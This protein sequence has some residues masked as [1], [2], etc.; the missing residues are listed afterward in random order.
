MTYCFESSDILQL[1]ALLF[2]DLAQ[3]NI[4]I[5]FDDF[6]FS[7]IPDRQLPAEKRLELIKN[8]LDPG[9][10]AKAERWLKT[11]ETLRTSLITSPVDI[12]YCFSTLP[13]TPKNQTLAKLFQQYMDCDLSLDFTFHAQHLIDVLKNH[14]EANPFDD[15]L[16]FVPSCRSYLFSELAD[17]LRF[18]EGVKEVTLVEMWEITP[19]KKRPNKKLLVG[20]EVHCLEALGRHIKNRLDCGALATQIFVPFFGEPSELQYFKHYLEHLHIPYKSYIDTDK[21]PAATGMLERI[22]ADTQKP[23][24]ERLQ[25][26]RAWVESAPWLPQSASDDERLSI[27][28]AG[29]LLSEEQLQYF[30][31]LATVPCAPPEQTNGVRIVPF[32]PQPF[33]KGI[34]VFPYTG[35]STLVPPRANLLLEDT[36]MERLNREGFSLPTARQYRARQDTFLH[37]FAAGRSLLF[38]ANQP[39]SDDWKSY[40]LQTTPRTLEHSE[41]YRPT[42]IWNRTLSAT[43]LETYARCPALYFY[44]YGLRLK[45]PTVRFESAFALS[46]GQIVHK[47]LENVFKTE[48]PATLSSEEIFYMRF[49]ES[50][51]ESFPELKE[52]HPFVTLLC[53]GFANIPATVCQLEKRLKEMVG[54]VETIGL[55]VD[56]D[57]S[58][59]GATVRGKIDRIVKT[60]GG[61]LLILDYKTGNVDFSPSHIAEGVHFQGPVYCLAARQRWNLPI[62]GFLFYDL[63]RAE[64]RRGMLAEEQVGNAA[65]K[66]LTRGHLVS[67]NTFNQIEEQAVSHIGRV[68]TLSSQGQF[69]PTPSQEACRSC[70]YSSLCRRNIHH[71]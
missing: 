50:I 8:F 21:P 69:E 71:G 41:P 48:V 33:V 30:V 65:R 38:L 61:G 51:K 9:Q 16:I 1:F 57:C 20:S 14:E 12:E 63:K 18:A 11:I 39:P 29:K 64:L 40:Y 62:I 54:A 26:T 42:C 13:D 22:R 52:N 5:S 32:H 31:S 68:A 60:A 37:T 44:A 25:L 49:N 6:L 35:P 59:A 2:P 47:V 15:R 27:L 55:E 53:K 67:Q 56:F 34:M 58:L 7:C 10:H 24:L 28:G 45:P 3:S 17:A 46:F 19:T 43:Q 36:E 4:L 70:Q 23:L 66:F